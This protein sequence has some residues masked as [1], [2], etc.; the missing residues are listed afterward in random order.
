MEDTCLK[1][2]QATNSSSLKTLKQKQAHLLQSL[3]RSIQWTS[4]SSVIQSFILPSSSSSRIFRIL[5]SSGASAL[6]SI[7]RP[8][9]SRPKSVTSVLS[10][11]TMIF[12]TTPIPALDVNNNTPAACI[13]RLAPFSGRFV[14]GTSCKPQ[15]S[16]HKL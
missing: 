12:R 7:L 4:L 9:S 5:T 15:A 14:E 6:T 3:P 11:D 8:S 13:V 10:A 2:M 1:D 16:S